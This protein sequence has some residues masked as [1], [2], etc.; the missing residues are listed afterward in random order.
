MRDKQMAF[1]SCHHIER[2][3]IDDIEYIT[4]SKKG[5]HRE[6]DFGTWPY[7]KGIGQSLN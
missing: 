2:L 3:A 7:M 5:I 6:F 1:L 4:I